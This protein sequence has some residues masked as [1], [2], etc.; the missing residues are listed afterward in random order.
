MYKT[1]QQIADKLELSYTIVNIMTCNDSK[2]KRAIGLGK[3]HYFIIDE[4]FF[5]NLKE[6]INKKIKAGYKKTVYY[7]N[8]YL[9]LLEWQKSIE[10]RGLK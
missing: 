1:I 6:E 9:N 10:K 4:D 2:F 5:N 3:A 7:K 8:A